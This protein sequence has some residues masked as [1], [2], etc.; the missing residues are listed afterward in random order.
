MRSIEGVSTY[1]CDWLLKAGIDATHKRKCQL[2][3]RI[4]QTVY[5]QLLLYSVI[6]DWTSWALTYDLSILFPGWT[7]CHVANKQAQTKTWNII[8][9]STV[10]TSIVVFLCV[11]IFFYKQST[12]THTYTHNPISVTSCSPK[13]TNKTKCNR[14]GV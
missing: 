1:Q 12:D 7:R 4:I 9:E 8:P 14:L 6:L 11:C 2:I 10:Y 3:D 13:S 5:K